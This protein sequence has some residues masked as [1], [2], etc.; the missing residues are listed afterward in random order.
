MNIASHVHG[1]AT[2]IPLPARLVMANAA[3]TRTAIKRL[4]DG[5]ATRV[6][7]D[8][9]GV[10]F[11]DSS[12]LSVLISAFEAAQSRGGEAVLLSPRAGVRALIELTRLHEVF[13]IY[14]DREA[15]I[16]ALSDA[17]PVR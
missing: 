1:N 4:V 13:P 3:E 9:G 14:E 12:G 5:G 7:L 15:A 2:L 16:R 8:L 6:I 11:V 10:E 17:E